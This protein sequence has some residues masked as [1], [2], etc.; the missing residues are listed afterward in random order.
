MSEAK[1]EPVT[2]TLTIDCPR[3]LA[4]RVFTEGIGRWWPLASHSVGA[5]EARTVAF[6]P[7]VGGR[8][9][10][11]VAEGSEHVWGHVSV[12]DPPDCVSFSWHPG[13]A[14][15]TAQQ[16]QVVFEEVDGSTRVS[17]LHDGWERLGAEAQEA[18]D[19][20]QTGWDPVLAGYVES[21]N[22]PAA[23]QVV[24]HRPGPGWRAGTPYKEQPGV[25]EHVAYMKSLD[26][27]GVMVLGGPFLDDS[28]GMVVLSASSI[29]VARELAEADP[30]VR[31]G[32]LSAE[33]RTWM[34]PTGTA[35]R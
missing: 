11:T 19:Q 7:H 33:I 26:A 10:E 9:F 13:R 3:V 8:L 16:V 5:N 35:V 28:G 18:R 24:F 23:F 6:E 30:G 14:G 17:L 29:D 2:K 22:R 15:E 12:W 34:T 1:F 4:F 20:Y 32:L 21:V 25:A 31:S 27:R